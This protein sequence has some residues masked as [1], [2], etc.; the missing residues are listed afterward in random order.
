MTTINFTCPQCSHMMQLPAAYIGK[1]GKCPSC[2]NAVLITAPQAAA[3]PQE[4][5]QQQPLQQQTFQQQ[6]LQQQ[7]EISLGDQVNVPSGSKKKILIVVGI[8][9]GCLMILVIAT[10]VAANFAGIYSQSKET[11]AK[12]QL[13]LVA[14]QL[15][16]YKLDMNNYPPAELGLS[17]LRTQPTD[18]VGA[19]RWAGPYSQ[20]EIPNDPW[21]SSYQYGLE[22][23]PISGEN[24]YKIW[25]NG[26]SGTSNGDAPDGDDISVYSY[27]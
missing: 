14:Q 2:T 19:S 26:P 5:L 21:G 4:P 20:K 12:T 10:L 1:Q 3:T 16:F 13:D 23:D 22:T 11:A 27:K 6:P 18:P 25:S 8:V 17:A 7:Q 15:E 9:V 24:G